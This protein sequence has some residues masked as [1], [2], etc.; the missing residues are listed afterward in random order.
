MEVEVVRSER[1][2]KTVQARLVDGVVRVHIPASMTEDEERHW[3]DRMVERVMKRYETDDDALAERAR[4]LAAKLGLPTPASIVWSDRQ[5]VLWGSCTIATGHIRISSRL[6]DFP[7]WVLDYVIVHE[8]AHLVEPN[9]S[10]A[11][12]EIVGR[13]GRAERARGFLVAK[14]L[15]ERNGEERNGEER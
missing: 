5:R 7:T 4:S 12:W 14:G 1:R 13:Y 3:V 10:P 2:K 15:E 11:F 9:H 6:V 8:L